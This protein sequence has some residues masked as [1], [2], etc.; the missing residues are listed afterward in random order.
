MSLPNFSFRFNFE[1]ESAA[2]NKDFNQKK[3]LLTEHG[4]HQ[5]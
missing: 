4:D 1:I 2:E 5:Q 3:T